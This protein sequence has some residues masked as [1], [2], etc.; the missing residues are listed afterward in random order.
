MDIN[1]NKSFNLIIPNMDKTLDLAIARSIEHSFSFVNIENQVN[2]PPIRQVF[3][4]NLRDGFGSWIRN[5]SR[6]NEGLISPSLGI[7]NTYPPISRSGFGFTVGIKIKLDYKIRF[8][9]DMGM[10]YSVGGENFGGASTLHFSMYNHGLG[11][12]AREKRMVYDVTASA[13][14]IGGGG[15]GIPM[16]NYLLNY[17]TLSPFPDRHK[18]SAMWGQMLTWNSELNHR[19]F[20]IKDIQRQGL[21]GFRLGNIIKFSTNNDA[22]ILPYLG[23]RFLREKTD[24]GWTGGLILYTPLFEIGYQSFTGTGIAFDGKIAPVGGTDYKGTYYHQDSYN[25]SLNKASSYLRFNNGFNSLT[26]DFFGDGWF[27]NWIHK[28]YKN[29]KFIYPH[30]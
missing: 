13:Y 3:E 15:D 7:G 1:K 18:W 28:I 8:N 10:G 16:P 6:S 5:L 26:L 25:E 9:F 4:N 2:L 14:I 11:T 24:N 19:S 29:P 30:F 17:N 21:F 22:T 27:Q 23:G 20:S 12:R